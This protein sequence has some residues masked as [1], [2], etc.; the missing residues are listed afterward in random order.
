M[1]EISVVETDSQT[2]KTDLGTLADPQQTASEPPAEIM[3][4]ADK[5]NSKGSAEV[6]Q[7]LRISGPV[8]IKVSCINCFCL[9]LKDSSSRQG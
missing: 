1:D 7:N 3:E 4:V 8:R 5:L 6:D 9:C 2:P